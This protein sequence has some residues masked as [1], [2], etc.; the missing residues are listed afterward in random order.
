M[1]PL[2]RRRQWSRCCVL[3]CGLGFVSPFEAGE[4]QQWPAVRNP[5]AN[6]AAIADQPVSRTARRPAADFGSINGVAA[7]TAMPGPP[8][9]FLP[10][11]NRAPK[12][13]PALPTETTPAE[14][15]APVPAF[16]DSQPQSQPK[17]IIQPPDRAKLSDVSILAEPE[18][19]F[20]NAT[21]PTVVHVGGTLT[22]AAPCTL[23]S[24][25]IEGQLRWLRPCRPISDFKSVALRKVA[26]KGQGAVYWEPV[27]YGRASFAKLRSGAYDVC[28]LRIPVTN[29]D[30]GPPQ[31]LIATPTR[32]IILEAKKFP[33]SV[34][35][36][37]WEASESQLTSVV[38]RTSWTP[39][40]ESADSQDSKVVDAL[41]TVEERIRRGWE[42]LDKQSLFAARKK[43]AQAYGLIRDGQIGGA[44]SQSAT[45]VDPAA[46]VVAAPEAVAALRQQVLKHAELADELAKV[47]GR[48]KRFG[49]LFYGL[50][51]TY[52]AIWQESEAAVDGAE[53][54]AEVCYLT[55]LRLDVGDWRFANDLAV[56]LC[57]RGEFDRAYECLVRASEGKPEP[58]MAYNLGCIL[59]K[60]DRIDEA[61]QCW[62]WAFGQRPQFTP[63]LHAWLGTTFDRQAN[64]LYSE[65]CQA[66]V[67]ALNQLCI[68]QRDNT[69]AAK[70]VQ[71]LLKQLEVVGREMELNGGSPLGPYFWAGIKSDAEFSSGARSFDS[72]ESPDTNAASRSKLILPPARLPAF[73]S[74]LTEADRSTRRNT[75]EAKTR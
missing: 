40:Q 49:T 55:A 36:L 54:L 58:R 66:L 10:K 67:A 12:P 13:I 9:K 63:A 60:L 3:A 5:V 73:P 38:Q 65:D 8:P 21:Y 43:F 47:V 44:T 19:P 6:D 15:Q 22:I 20:R 41:A 57:R 24:E 31:D 71:G 23:E 48:Q 59:L 16:P 68:A 50:A 34:A 27:I 7:N 37:P 4:R 2:I 51:K 30:R 61:R 18:S 33:M 32:R 28:Y 75:T 25:V 26:G 45:N 74:D 62:S 52:E 56:L 14:S 64:A 39:P 17:T 69:A 72:R 35:A 46:V 11:M 70:Q 42:L 1:R 29:P 53:H